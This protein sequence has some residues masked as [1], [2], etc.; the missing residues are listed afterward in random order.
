M[1][2]STSGGFIETLVKAVAVRP[3]ICSPARMVT[4]VT[5]LAHRRIT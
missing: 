4:T 3:W 5:V 1:Q 2:T